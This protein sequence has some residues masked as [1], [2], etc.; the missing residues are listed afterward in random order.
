MCGATNLGEALRRIVVG[1]ARIR[2]KSEVGTGNVV[3]ATRHMRVIR[4]EI[5]RLSA[6]DDEMYAAAKDL[7]TRDARLGVPRPRRDHGRHQPG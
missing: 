1:V 4:A 5:R 2:S 7:R 3:E 6:V